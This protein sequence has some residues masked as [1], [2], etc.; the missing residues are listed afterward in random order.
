MKALLNVL[1]ICSGFLIFAQ[2][3]LDDFLSY[4]FPSHLTAADHMGKIAWVVNEKGIRNV[5]SAQAPAYKAV[6]ETQYSL[7]DGIEISQLLFYGSDLIFVR[8][9]APNR[10]GEF[11]N[12]YLD[13]QGTDQAIFLSSNKRVQKLTEGSGPLLRGEVMCFINKGQIYEYDFTDKLA[14]QLFTTRGQIGS[15]RLSPDENKLAFISHRGDHAFLGIYDFNDQSITYPDPTVDIDSDPVWSPESNQ[16]A[17]LRRPYDPRLMF[18]SKLAAQPFSIRLINIEDG[19][20]KTLWQADEGKGSAF[21]GLS[22]GQQLFWMLNNEI[23]FPWEKEGWLH[24]YAVSTKEGKAKLLTPGNFEIQYVSQS[25]DR[26]FLLFSSN[27][28]DLNRQHIGKWKD[29]KITQIT[30]GKGIEWSPVSDGLGNNFALGSSG[31]EPAAVKRLEQGKINTIFSSEDYPSSDLT[32]PEAVYFQR[33]TVSKFMDSCF[34][35]K[36]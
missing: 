2:K 18:I 24:L 4:S 32:L 34:Y 11:P 17:V 16:I 10:E 23:I 28:G 1:F 25:P 33:Q 19:E 21:Y 13:V 9:S 5:Y 27:R 8:G 14:R 3:G 15:L 20:S 12:P 22:S 6:K 36:D 29:S 35:Q 26:S 31:L 30:K 7:D